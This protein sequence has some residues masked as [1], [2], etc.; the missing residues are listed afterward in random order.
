MPES[1]RSRLMDLGGVTIVLL[2]IALPFLLGTLYMSY[3]TLW[4]KF[5]AT[6]V[7]ATVV[8]RTGSRSSAIIAEYTA[9]NGLPMRTSSAG[10]D[11]Y[12]DIAV[13]QTVT[14]YY[15]PKR[16]ADA[17]I[18]HFV[19]NWIAP[20]VTLIPGLILLLAAYVLRANATSTYRLR[21]PRRGTVPIQAEFVYVRVG[22]DLHG[23][24]R[25][26]AA[27]TGSF[28]INEDEDGHCHL[29]H[30]GVARDAY[31]PA[32]QRELGLFNFVCAR[33]TDP[34]TRK[35]HWFESEPLEHNPQARLAG[36]TITVHIDPKHPQRYR[37][38]LPPDASATS[39]PAAGEFRGN[40]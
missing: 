11:F 34:Q 23:R 3:H 31:D 26:P 38:D 21:A 15:D 27:N 37:M 13:G 32:V 10:S 36:R 35:R 30:N 20:L 9:P 29:I 16:P 25:R 33:W 39:V 8:E 24:V 2:A 17:R 4:F 19:E 1:K 40:V 28:S 6:Q 12:N 22:V 18:D 7:T 5:A 14:L